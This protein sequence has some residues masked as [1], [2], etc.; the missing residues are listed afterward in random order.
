MPSFHFRG[1]ALRVPT[2]KEN[3]PNGFL[4]M[5]TSLLTDQSKSA[6]TLCMARP[7]EF[8]RDAAVERAMSVF[9]L[10]GYAATSTDDL[11]RAMKIGRQ[12]MYDTFGDKHRLYLEALER[13]QRES[14]AENV[15]RLRSTDSPLAG[16]EAFVIG[17]LAADRSARERGC[18]GVGSISEF[19]TTDPDLVALRVKSASAQHRALIERLRHAQAANE[20][21]ANVDIERAAR[22]VEITMFG[23][24]V[25][26]K[27]GV[28]LQAL[29]DT[30]AFAIASLRNR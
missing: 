24:Q 8:D 19:G 14:V 5:I 13:Y 21:G 22:F 1:D 18:M 2:G 3:G 7:R 28:S 6:K 11:L 9:W 30:A 12:S 15:G 10:K 27:A 16:I 20:I 17:L 25:A 29:R 4:F 23:L 26:A